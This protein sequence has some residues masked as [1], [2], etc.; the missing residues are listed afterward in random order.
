MPKEMIN[1]FAIIGM[2]STMFF[3]IGG[4]FMLYEIKRAKED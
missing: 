2:M 1:F 3:G 4:I